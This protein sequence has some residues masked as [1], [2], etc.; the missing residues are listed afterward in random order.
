MVDA[1]IK[2]LSLLKQNPAVKISKVAG[3]RH[4]TFDMNAQM[5]PFNDPNVRMALKYAIDRQ[6]ILNKAF[7]G[8]AK[9]ANDDPIAPQIRFAIDPQPVHTYDVAKAKEYLQKSGL[10]TLAVDLSVA[11]TAFPGAVEAALLFKE[12]AAKAGITINV[13]READDGYW[14]KVWQ[15]KAFVGVD[16]LGKPTCDSLFTTVYTTNAPWSDTGWSNPRFDK[17]IVEGEPSLTR[18]SGN[19]YMARCSS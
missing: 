13:I 2:T 7:L 4:W 16:W 10:Q 11:E 18:R 8:N 9:V 3:L 1:D 15:H 12:H 17:L 5:A 6:D 14:D 19:R